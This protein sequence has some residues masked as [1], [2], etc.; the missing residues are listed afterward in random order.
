MPLKPAT[1]RECGGGVQF[2]AATTGIFIMQNKAADSCSFVQPE[3]VGIKRKERMPS[4]CTK[5]VL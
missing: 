1:T 2:T 3:K 4:A 5:E